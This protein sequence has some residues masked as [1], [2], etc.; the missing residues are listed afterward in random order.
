MPHRI[1]GTN[2]QYEMD[3]NP[4]PGQPTGD[5]LANRPLGDALAQLHPDC[6]GWALGCC[7]WNREEAEDV[8]QTVYLK[9]LDG[10]ARFAGRSSVKTWLFAVI[11]HTAAH[12]RRR[13]WL[14]DLL[15]QRLVRR[16]PLVETAADT[17]SI[18]IE[19]ETSRALR[20]AL[21][22]LPERQRNALHLVF[23]EGLSVE[24]AAVVLGISVGSARTHYHRGKERLRKLL[25]GGHA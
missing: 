23:Y 25:P 2:G 16:E 1:R 7:A 8:L 20:S 3:T 6:F 14:I 21:L 22:Q 4:D 18:A 17:E 11:R 15:P 19:A 10:S 9:V 5:P 12:R 24:E 13:Q